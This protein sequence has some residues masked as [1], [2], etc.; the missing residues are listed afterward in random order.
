MNS[1]KPLYNFN[2]V[3]KSVT[4]VEE[5]ED[6][7]QGQVNPI[8]DFYGAR[9]HAWKNDPRN[10]K[11]E[12]EM[13]T[14]SYGQ[15]MELGQRVSK[16]LS[17]ATIT[18]LHQS[19]WRAQRAR[20]LRALDELKTITD[21]LLYKRFRKFFTCMRC[22][23]LFF[24]WNKAAPPSNNWRDKLKHLPLQRMYCGFIC[25]VLLLNFI[26]S[27]LSFEAH[28][29]FDSQSF[30]KILACIFSYEAASRAVLSYWACQRTRGGYK[31]LF[32]SIDMICYSDKII[33]YEN[34]LRF[35]IRLMLAIS[36]LVGLA[37]TAT[38]AYGIFG[39]HNLQS[40]FNV[41][42]YPLHLEDGSTGLKVYK[43]MFIILTF[44]D[45][46]VAMLSL[47]FYVLVCSVLYQEFHYL[48]RTF[49]M[50]IREDGRFTDD[51][52]KFRQQHEKRC[53]LVMDADGIFKYCIANTFLANV[54]QLCLLLYMIVYSDDAV[55]LR[56]INSFKLAYVL[57]QM[58]V[59]SVAAT[60][61]NTQ[62]GK[63]IFVL[64]KKLGKKRMNASTVAH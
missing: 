4:P 38:M 37:N 30:F 51:I 28:E 19:S 11:V 23:G 39:P 58:M 61:I 21:V 33:P 31:S 56:F 29:E 27:I 12:P 24:I 52:E 57:M 41:Y 48:C 50:K 49:S 63:K 22:M 10:Q 45:G 26:R 7:D 47:S 43:A 16:G 54:P 15:E 35:R 46:M 40:I 1:V 20:R 64:T 8:L 9:K 60:L 55:G 42:I 3:V 62:V 2:H 44:I 5:K 18:R 13:G 32:L 6:E 17:I 36:F 59:V 34:T 53:Q 25:V 14:G